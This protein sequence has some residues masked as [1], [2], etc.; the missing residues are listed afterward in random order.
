MEEE[1]TCSERAL[2]KTNDPLEAWDVKFIGGLYSESDSELNEHS[3]CEGNNGPAVQQRSSN[4]RW[5]RKRILISIYCEMHVL[6]ETPG[7]SVV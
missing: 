5:P 4:G 1:A 7:Y 2:T 3:I 6:N